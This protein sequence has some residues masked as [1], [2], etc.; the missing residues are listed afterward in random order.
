M[1]A[2][3]PPPLPTPAP[4]RAGAGHKFPPPFLMMEIYGPPR[5]PLTLCCARQAAMR[6]CLAATMQETPPCYPHLQNK[7]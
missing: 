5:L 1:P 4:R 7:I 2:I 6:Q 3:A